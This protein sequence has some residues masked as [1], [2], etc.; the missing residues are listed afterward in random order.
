MVSIPAGASGMGLRRFTVS[1]GVGSA[2]WNGALIG[3][4]YALGS[5]WENAQSYTRYFEYG[6][7]AFMAG[8]VILFIVR[9]R[10]EH[11]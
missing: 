2:V 1:T 11:T 7:F 9:R 4:G 3:I 8:S 5:N 6:V 10:R